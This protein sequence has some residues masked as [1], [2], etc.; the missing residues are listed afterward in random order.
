MKQSKKKK[1]NEMKQSTLS[2]P[3]P[4]VH[5]AENSGMIPTIHIVANSIPEAYYM[6]I[7]KVHEEGY[8]LTVGVVNVLDSDYETATS[9]NIRVVD[10]APFTGITHNSFKQNLKVIFSSDIIVLANSVFGKG[11]IR[12]LEAARKAVDQGKAVILVEST[13]FVDRNFAG[14]V[15]EKLYNYIRQKATLVLKPEEVLNIIDS[16]KDQPSHKL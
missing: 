8:T 5:V 6:A 2:G 10:E 11:N 4:M 1:E 14:K 12:N 9:L 3:F 7:K 13:P 16:I 15:S